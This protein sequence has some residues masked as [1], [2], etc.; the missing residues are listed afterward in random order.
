[1]KRRTM[2]PGGPEEMWDDTVCYNCLTELPEVDPDPENTGASP[3]WDGYCSTSCRNG[4]PVPPDERM[5]D[6]LDAY[7]HLSYVTGYSDES[8]DGICDCPVIH[9][10][11]QP[12]QRPEYGDDGACTTCS[13]RENRG[14]WLACF[15]FRVW[16]HPSRGVLVAYHSVLNSDSGGFIM[17][18]ERGV[19]TADSA[20]F[21]LPEYWTGIGMEHTDWTETEG[22]DAASCQLRW[23]QDLQNA[24]DALSEASQ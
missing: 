6:E 5:L 16:R 11:G 12:V 9:R 17:D 15:D 10:P 18:G 2:Y 14:D 19:A 21:T 4:D 23:K 8:S 24:I 1:M 13:G 20:P 22:S 7:G 3:W